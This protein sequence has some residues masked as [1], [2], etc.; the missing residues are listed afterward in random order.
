MRYHKWN[1]ILISKELCKIYC[2]NNGR[3]TQTDSQQTERTRITGRFASFLLFAGLSLAMFFHSKLKVICMCL[4]TKPCPDL[5]D[6]MDYSPPGSSVH[7]ISLA[8]TLTQGLNPC[9]L[10]LLHW[11]ADS[12]PVSYLGSL[13][14]KVKVDY[15]CVWEIVN[16]V[17]NW[18]RL[19]MCVHSCTYL[20]IYLFVL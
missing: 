17:Y 3:D 14:L 4:V 8:R 15:F 5:Y 13:K 19:F 9:L 6:P 18:L 10:W 20:F 12:L 2:N 7:R 1:H 16:V 11:Q